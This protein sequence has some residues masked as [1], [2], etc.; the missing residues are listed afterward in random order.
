[1]RRATSWDLPIWIAL[2]LVDSIELADGQLARS[3]VKPDEAGTRPRDASKFPGP[4]GVGRWTETVY[5][6]LLNCGLRIPPTAGSSSGVSPSP[7]GYNRVYVHVDPPFSYEQWLTNLRAGQV[8]VTNGPLIRPN[9][10]GELPGHVFQADAGQEVALEVGLTLSTRDPVSYLE[11]VENG[12]SVYEVR[13]DQWVEAKGKLPPLKFKESSWFVVRAV[14]DLGTTHRFASTG[15]Y[16]V[17]IGYQPR[18]SRA[19]VQF[20]LDWLEAREAS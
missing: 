2:G 4:A 20:F 5:Y 18:I 3:G 12:R 15:P 9:V 7:I 1:M 11:I 10:G 8:V 14:T 17:E 6:N 19:A 16:Y 13:L